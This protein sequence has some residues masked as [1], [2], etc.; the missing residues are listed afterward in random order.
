MYCIQINEIHFSTEWKL[1]KA[2][3]ERTSREDT[4]KSSE[5]IE[6]V[7]VRTA[8]IQ[9]KFKFFELYKEP[10]QERRQFRI[11]PPRDPSQVKVVLRPRVCEIT[12][13]P[14]Y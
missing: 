9:E 5:Q 10:E 8:D 6:E 1:F 7:E 2:Y 4:V 3:L 12:K 14:P 11:T 13:S